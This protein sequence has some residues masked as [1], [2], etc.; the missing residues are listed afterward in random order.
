MTP[1]DRVEELEWTP[2]PLL[3]GVASLKQVQR[4]LAEPPR[5]HNQGLARGDNGGFRDLNTRGEPTA[6]EGYDVDLFITRRKTFKRPYSRP[7]ETLLHGNMST[8]TNHKCR[9][10]QCKMAM[11]DYFRL[12]RAK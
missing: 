4:L 5:G 10:D 9:C 2:D 12:R 8:Y 6:E 1:R 3:W 11:R 7:P